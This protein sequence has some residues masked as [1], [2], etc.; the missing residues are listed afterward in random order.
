MKQKLLRPIATVLVLALLA[1]PALA[2]EKSGEYSEV[3]FWLP[4][5]I[6]GAT[7][8][9]PAPSPSHPASTRPSPSTWA[10][11]CGK[12]EWQIRPAAAG[13]GLA[14]GALY[15]SL[16]SLGSGDLYRRAERGRALSIVP[17]PDGQGGSTNQFFEDASSITVETVDGVR[18]LVFRRGAPPAEGEEGQRHRLAVSGL[19]K[20]SRAAGAQLGL[21]PEN[22]RTALFSDVSGKDWFDLWVDLS[23]N[24]GLME[25]AGRRQILALP[26]P[27]RW[28]GAE[29]GRCAGQPP[30]KSQT[31]QSGG[32]LVSK[33]G[34]YCVKKT[35]L[36]QSSTF[37]DYARPITRAEMALVSP[38]PPP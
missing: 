29:A 9:P 37:D 36:S 5:V 6:N 32:S 34:G 10:P 12:G 30:E 33:R 26:H 19:S 13:R 14:A 4:R 35:A 11:P 17:I 38:L 31:F 27:H 1:S 23:Y 22:G 15:G 16:T 18:T 2:W 25:G 28:R 3:W 7:P 21:S 20:R 8:T 24:L